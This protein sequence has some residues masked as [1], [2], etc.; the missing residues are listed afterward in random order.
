[1]N[2]NRHNYEEYFIL[3]MDNEL[4][5]EERRM[6]ESFVQLHPDLK[7]ELDSLPQYKLEPDAG[8]VY[9]GKEELMKEKVHS[10]VTLS[11]YEEWLSLYTDDELNPGQKMLVEKFIAANP[12]AGK[13]FE[14]WQRTKLPAETVVFPDKNLLYRRDEKVRRISSFH[15]RAAAAVLIIIA[16]IS[17][18]LVLNNKPSGEKADVVVTN[19]EQ[20]INPAENNNLRQVGDNTDKEVVSEKKKALLNI[21][22]VAREKN[23]SMA[24]SKNNADQNKGAI[25]TERK[26]VPPAGNH[27]ANN[28]T[29]VTKNNE[30][31]IAQN[32]DNP[33]NNLPQPLKNPNIVSGY[34]RDNDVA[35]RKPDESNPVNSSAEKDVTNTTPQ[36]S[37]MVP[38]SYKENEEM[39]EQPDGRKN[40]N[41]GI[42]R[43]IA[44]TFEKRT[45]MDPTDDNRLLVAGL[46]IKLK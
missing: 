12:P 39:F 29:A 4:S 40:K 6:V 46:A 17:A 38:V 14:R 35:Y 9:E 24:V 25:A 31:I 3:Y 8:I 34:N 22:F 26:T 27:T 28:L 45:N 37:N 2:I 30:P 33:S 19:Q 7:E 42:F 23:R 16:G 32:S 10:P 18:V 5:A 1:M 20:A 21:P 15:W 13:D 41:R 44:R 36:L 43:K 11:N